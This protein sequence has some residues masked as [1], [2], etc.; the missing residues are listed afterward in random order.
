MAVEFKLP[1]LGENVESADVLDVLVKPGDRVEKEQPVLEAETEKAT[2]EIPSS[3][4]GVVKEVN[5]SKGDTIKVGQLVLTL[6]EAEG[7]GKAEAPKKEEPK[8]EEKPAEPE[9]KAEKQEKPAE[10]PTRPT[11]TDVSPDAPQTT[12]ASAPPPAPK[13]D[14]LPIAA[15][16]STRQF[17]REIGVDIHEV[18]GTEAGGRI[19]IEDVKNHARS[20]AASGGGGAATGPRSTREPMSKVRKVTARHMAKAWATIPHVTIHDKADVT[21]IERMRQR[22]K[23]KAEQAGG[24]LTITAIFVKVVASAL[25]SFP[26]VNASIDVESSEIEYK[27]FYNI[28]VAV[29]TPRGLVVPV[30][31]DADEKSVFEIAREL[32]EISGKARDGKLTL[33]D[34]SGGTFTI[35]NLGS[36]GTGFFTPIVNHPEVGILGM[37]RALQEPVFKDGQFV[38][39]LLA[40]LSLSFDHRL[41]DGADGARFLRW[42]VDA[43]ENPLLM[44]FEN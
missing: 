1:D 33:E 44:S 23:K 27:N 7:D 28:G 25:R 3:V 2:M 22:F 10:E 9:K 14:R 37:G 41:V 36:I 39:R 11:P 4:A 32:T 30:I 12:V 43:A 19:S 5:V 34:M 15:A 20:R 8:Q 29:D 24:K 40:P 38:P 16:P 18:E 21:D 42:I 35:T 31:R 17:A 6:D 13:G 26:S